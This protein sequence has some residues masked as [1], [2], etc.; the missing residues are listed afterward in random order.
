MRTRAVVAIILLLLPVELSAQR[1]RIPGIAGRRPRPAE[2]PPQPPS[3]ARELAYK[4][5]RFSVES[6]PL[7]SYVQSSGFVGDGGAS[8]WT[9]FGMGTR[10]DYRIAPH[11]SAT[12]DMTSS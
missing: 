5:L 10:V 2:L 7:V 3:I 9:S 6:Y 8:S 4:R 11:L 12:M 1:L